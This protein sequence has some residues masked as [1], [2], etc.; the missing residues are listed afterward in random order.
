MD[1]EYPPA[2]AC[3]KAGRRAPSCEGFLRNSM[4]V[5]TVFFEI[6]TPL[7]FLKRGEINSDGLR[8]FRGGL[9]RAYFLEAWFGAFGTLYKD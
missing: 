6:E 3:N 8:V 5:F 4:T 7:E 9:L 1:A 2:T